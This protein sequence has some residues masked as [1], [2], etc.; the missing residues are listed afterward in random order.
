MRALNDV[1]VVELGDSL[2]V[3]WCGRQFA[4]WGAD[5]VT[6]E[7]EGG[8][9]IRRRRPLADAAEGPISLLWETVAAG[10]VSARRGATDLVDLLS[11]TDVLLLD[12]AEGLD[13][14]DL[15][16]Q[17]PQ[18][19]VVEM[20][21]FGRD[22]PYAGWAA[23]E[24]VVQALS[25]YLHHNGK[26]G[27]PPLKAP[28]HILA[29]ACGVSAFVAALA[30]LVKRH[31]RGCG[32]VI[33]A[34]ELETLASLTPLLRG[35]YTGVHPVRS[36]GPGTGV[37]L[38]K[39]LDGS[40][41]FMPPTPKQL[42]EF[43]RAL[44]VARDDWPACAHDARATGRAATLMEFLGQLLARRP[45]KAVFRAML[46]AGVPCGLAQ[47]PGDLLDEPHL[48]A[49]G[50]FSVVNHPRLGPLPL[51]GAPAH[52]SRTPAAQP[53]PAPS[54][55]S[56]SAPPW[57]P[58]AG[59]PPHTRDLPLAG[60]RLLDLTQAW[61]GPYAAMLLADL[62]AETVKIESHRRPDV[63]RQWS[64][65][66][67]PLTDVNADEVN[68][69]PNYNSVNLN[70]R[71]L[72]LDL[73]S[74]AGR[75][76][77]LRLAREADL[78]MENYTPRVLE[79]LGLDHA[80][81]ARENRR[82]VM[83]SFCGFG[84]T[85]PLSDFKANGT[86][87]E[88]IAGWDH[89]HRYPGEDPIV[90]GFYQADAISGL[91][92]AAVT[93]V[94]LLHSLRTGEGQAI[95]GSMYEAAAGYIGEAL[96]E[97][98]LG[99]AQTSAGNADPDYAPSG[100][101]PCAGEDRWIAISVL[102][103]DQWQ[104]LVGLAPELGAYS[105]VAARLADRAALESRI[106]DWTIGREP[107]GLAAALQAASIPAAVVRSPAEVLACPHLSGRDWFRSLVHADV[108]E[109]LHNGAPWRFAG[110]PPRRE[111]ASPRLGEH[112]REILAERLG[113]SD[114]EISRLERDNVTGA[115]LA[116]ARP[117]RQGEK[118]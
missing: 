55:P 95:D 72:T 109:H 17:H 57:T 4:L 90:M 102:N 49:R 27:R 105:D 52:L 73:K 115:V 46:E 28:G 12:G 25:G 63:W 51:A 36:G 97:A 64:A 118:P 13:P 77:L 83:T 82:M 5:V 15:A 61:I 106:A 24:L 59:G 31:K 112:S 3:A 53:A 58:R 70:K 80:T 8:S 18:L 14:A 30:A 47:S 40:V 103:E 48:A 21:G 50:F 93:L 84:K 69:S 68:A 43:E 79:R 94:A 41:S 45:A 2:P 65:A 7:P 42:G 20:S 85:G 32:S 9:T 62:G 114:E 92:M 86:T 101:F 110:V 98:R 11:R 111:C 10:K 54:R 16:A 23:S 34:T 113:L 87:I 56:P 1:R 117:E 96:M 116:K 67:V 74:E 66:P 88:A 78:V 60:I 75:A 81:L 108:G 91:Q 44:G 100:V 104:A 76:V 26:S 107:E 6:L 71:S 35:Q 33:D 37:R 99:L 22:G 19:I 29:Y 38:L 89:F 39:C